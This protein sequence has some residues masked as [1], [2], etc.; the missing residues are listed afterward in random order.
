MCVTSILPRILNCLCSGHHDGFV[1][2]R[3]L[4]KLAG[5]SN[6][7]SI[8]YTIRLLGEYVVEII[9]DLQKHIFSENIEKYVK[10]IRE[11]PAYWIKTKH[12]VTSYWNAYYRYPQYPDYATPEYGSREEYIGQ[13]IV[14]GL[15]CRNVPK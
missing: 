4:M 9:E 13:V 7:F 12:R 10:F 1:R 3:A 11:N 5:K 8:P 15:E 6:D 14:D 2:Q